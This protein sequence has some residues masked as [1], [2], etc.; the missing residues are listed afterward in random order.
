MSY[1]KRQFR[2]INPTPKIGTVRVSDSVLE[3]G[4]ETPRAFPS[5]A[6]GF[7]GARSGPM[8]QNRFAFNTLRP[9]FRAAIPCKGSGT[10]RSA[11]LPKMP[12]R[13]SEGACNGFRR[14]ACPTRS[15]AGRHSRANSPWRPA[16]A[17]NTPPA[18]SGTTRFGRL[19][20]VPL[21]REPPRRAIVATPRRPS[22]TRRRRPQSPRSV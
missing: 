12:A 17:G 8:W 9:V 2:W 3:S 15:Q 6:Q 14:G 19:P 11:R 13:E 18:R 5:W 4:S 21:A 20:A 22:S 16:R 7:A 1:Y 10:L